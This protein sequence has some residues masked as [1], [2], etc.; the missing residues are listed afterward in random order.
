MQRVA[1][2]G[3]GYV[4][5]V[6]GACLAQD[7]HSVIGV[8][9]DAGK[10]A[11]VNAGVSP[12]SEPGLDEILK[13]QV[14]AGRLR[15]TTD[16][17]AAVAES[18]TALVAVGTPSADD[19]SVSAEGVERVVRRIGQAVRGTGK[20]YRVVI[21]STLLPGLL[22]GL[23]RPAL[24]EAAG[25]TTGPDL[26]LC[27]NPEFLRESSAV[28]DYYQPP[29]VLVGADSPAEAAPVLGLYHAVEGEQIVTDTRTASL[30]KYACNAYHAVKV[31][32]ANEIGSL[33]Q[34]LGADGHGVM[35]L[36]C[37]DRKLNV[38][39]AYLRPGFA[40]GGSCLPKDLRALTRFAEQQALRTHLLAAVLPSNEAH[41]KRALKLV[42]DTGV[43]RIGVVGLSFKAGTDDLRESPLVDVVEALIGWG[44]DV[45]I[46]DPNVMLGRLRGRNLAYIDRHLPHLANLLVPQTQMLI[47]HAGL[48]LLGTDV[49]NDY[50]WRGQFAGPVMDLRAD[51]ARP[52]APR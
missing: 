29:Y 51:L 21:R 43:R 36:V 1:V 24:E 14:A 27:N 18:D 13:T 3:V 17:D 48:L 10:V 38:S 31:A 45:K 26:V 44:C 8:D 5:C 46:Y 30:V 33:A 4:G 19:G 49:A 12:I 7:G 25:R 6:T 34:A 47:S 52:G 22:E 42:K 11:E 32:F 35:G 9:V 50:D 23:L 41:M 37:K 20:P 2:F 15:A 39:P 16:V 28:K 40:F